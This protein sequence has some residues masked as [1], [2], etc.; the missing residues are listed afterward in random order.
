MKPLSL[1]YVSSIDHMP[2]ERLKVMDPPGNTSFCFLFSNSLGTFLDGIP[3]LAPRRNPHY[4]QGQVRNT[5]S[6]S[7]SILSSLNHL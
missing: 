1:H 4:S 5:P 7:C 6:A 2:M 3:Y